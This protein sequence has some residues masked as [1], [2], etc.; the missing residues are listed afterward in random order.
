MWFVVF[1]NTECNIIFAP[2]DFHI[3]LLSGVRPN[4][5]LPCLEITRKNAAFPLK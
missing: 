5:G 1:Q 2:Y 4:A 3:D